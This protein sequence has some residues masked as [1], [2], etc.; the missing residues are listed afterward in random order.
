MARQ[1]ESMAITKRFLNQLYD[2]SG[3]MGPEFDPENDFT[4]ADRI[5]RRQPQRHN[6]WPFTT[7]GQRLL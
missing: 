7:Y 2:I 5:R 4:Y 3:P 1:A 6:A